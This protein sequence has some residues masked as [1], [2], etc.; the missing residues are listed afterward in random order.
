MADADHL[1]WLDLE[2]TGTDETKDS[3]IEIGCI[4][5]TPD[6]RD[7]EPTATFQRIISPSDEAL[8]RLLRNGIVREM[9]EAN[10]LLD[11]LLVPVPGRTTADLPPRLGQ[12]PAL[13]PDVDWDALGGDDA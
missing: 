13:S 7:K 12:E 4:L 6:L 9:H 3:I 10:G 8:G 2:T 5:T 1:L 11:D